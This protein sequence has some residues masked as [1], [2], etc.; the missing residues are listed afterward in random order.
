M[1]RKI[2]ILALNVMLIVGIYTGLANKT[3]SIFELIFLIVIIEL[4][5]IG[6]WLITKSE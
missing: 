3:D 1:L 5:L 2:F 4:L 6:I